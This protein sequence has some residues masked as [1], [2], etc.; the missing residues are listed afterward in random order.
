LLKEALDAFLV[1]LVARIQV[2]CMLFIKTI[3]AHQGSVGTT[4]PL[5]IGFWMIFAKNLEIILSLTNETFDN[6]VD[7]DWHRQISF[8]RTIVFALAS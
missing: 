4:V 5:S 8:N 3:F 2:I 1:Q 6:I 7:L